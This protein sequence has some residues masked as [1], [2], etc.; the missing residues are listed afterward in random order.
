[1]HAEAEWLPQDGMKKAAEY[2]LAPIHLPVLLGALQIHKT[3]QLD[4]RGLIPLKIPKQLIL[5]Y[6]E[7]YLH[8]IWKIHI[9]HLGVLITCIE[10]KISSNTHINS[11]H[12]FLLLDNL[13]AKVCSTYKVLEHNC[14]TV[15][16]VMPIA[17]LYIPDSNFTQFAKSPW[18]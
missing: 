8:F 6:Y 5:S 1:M 14:K 4:V 16:L 11:Y 18:P 13:I 17:T 2:T 10:L 9:S 7:L 15:I 12:Q 3:G